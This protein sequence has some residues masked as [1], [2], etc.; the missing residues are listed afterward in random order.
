MCNTPCEP[1]LESDSGHKKY[2]GEEGTLNP[3]ICLHLPVFPFEPLRL[4][5]FLAS[6]TF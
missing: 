6:S 4:D 1:N 2:S 5:D 3:Q